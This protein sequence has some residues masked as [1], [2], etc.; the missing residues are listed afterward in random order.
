MGHDW[1]SVLGRSICRNIF[2]LTLSHLVQTSFMCSILA[3][4]DWLLSWTQMFGTESFL[5][6]W[7][8][9]WPV[10][11]YGITNFA[12]AEIILS[13][14]N[15]TLNF[16]KFL[17]M[18]VTST[19]TYVDVSHV[20]SPLKFCK[21]IFVIAFMRATYSDTAQERSSA[22]LS[23]VIHFFKFR[24]MWVCHPPNYTV[25]SKSGKRCFLRVCNSAGTVWLKEQSWCNSRVET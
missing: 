8:F 6:N 12:R 16:V 18:N 1:M 14:S 4:Q 7:E 9:K 13:E 19:Q 24:F 15:L 11:C 17:Y 21:Q 2:H 5:S 25:T 23:T 20:N 22:I 3:L 10:L